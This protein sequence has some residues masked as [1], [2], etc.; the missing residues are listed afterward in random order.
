M[1]QLALALAA[2]RGDRDAAARFL[3]SVNADVWRLCEHF[4]HASVVADLV[5]ETMTRVLGALPRFRGDASARSW[6]LGIAWRV[7]ADQVRVDRR[8]AAVAERVGNARPPVC[9]NPFEL[10]DLFDAVDRLEPERRAAFVLTQYVGLRYDEA[11]DVLTCPVGTIRSRVARARLEL[12]EAL[13][14][15]VAAS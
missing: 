10:T 1:D 7:C 5:Q 13:R 4:G 2:G 3:R 14:D 11:A 15:A 9:E 6:V 12:Y 8:D